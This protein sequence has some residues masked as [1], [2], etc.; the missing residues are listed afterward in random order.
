[1][2]KPKNKEQE[3]R[4]GHYN[5]LEKIITIVQY[6]LTA[7]MVLVVLQMILYS[8][9]S[10]SMLRIA[11]IVSSGLA[12]YTMSLLSYS[13]LSWFRVNRALVILLYGLAA[14]LIAINIVTE[15]AIFEIALQEKPAVVT[16]QSDVSFAVLASGAIPKLLNTVQTICLILSF[17]LIWSGTILLLHQKV[18]RIGKVKF[19]VFVSTPLIV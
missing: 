14:A 5:I 19:W 18:Y 2:V 8:G 15:A 3:T 7:I 13:L 17:P 16:P 6:V 10:S 11:V 9:Y 12:I 1:M 4:R